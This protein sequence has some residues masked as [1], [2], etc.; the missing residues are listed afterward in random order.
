MDFIN[1]AKIEIYALYFYQL[2]FISLVYLCVFQTDLCHS[3]F[4]LKNEY[5][6]RTIAIKACKISHFRHFA[7]RYFAFAIFPTEFCAYEID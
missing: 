5:S 2:L 1:L 7:L 6:F 4:K 3:M